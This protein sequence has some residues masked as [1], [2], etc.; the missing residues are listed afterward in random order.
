MNRW[1]AATFR[2]WAQI[3]DAKPA[4]DLEIDARFVGE[5]RVALTL[6]PSGPTTVRTRGL[7]GTNQR[8]LKAGDAVR[9]ELLAP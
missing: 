9:I 1:L 2:R 6:C 7:N 4:F 3:L 5:H 8:Q